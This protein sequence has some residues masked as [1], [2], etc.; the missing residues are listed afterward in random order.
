MK[1]RKYTIKLICLDLDGTLLTS[2]GFIDDYTLETLNKLYD[3]GYIIA[4]ISGRPLNAV[5]HITRKLKHHWDIGMNGQQIYNIENDKLI[6][7]AMLHA[8][9]LN[10][11]YAESCNYPLICNIHDDNQAAICFPKKFKL[12]AVLYNFIEQ[13]RWIGKQKQNAKKHYFND[14]KDTKIETVGKICFAGQKK[15]IQK[16]TTTLTNKY[17]EYNCVRVGLNWLEVMDK[18]ISKGNAIN[19]L[20]DYYK[21]SKENVLSFGDGENDISMFEASGYSC[22]ME[23]AMDS[24]KLKASETIGSNNKKAIGIFLNKL[25]RKEEVND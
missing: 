5:K 11:L 22:A 2:S 25:I 6:T 13:F 21:F 17:P 1:T 16:L 3:K 18:S 8:T 20:I 7:K 15:Y 4:I 9:D 14:I 12:Y 10:K 23:N 24:V 19:Y